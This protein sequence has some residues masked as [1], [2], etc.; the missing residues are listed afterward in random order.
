MDL[1]RESTTS[2][3]VAM[4]SRGRKVRRASNWLNA[5]I[6]GIQFPVSMA[7]GYFWGRER[8]KWF[9][10]APWLTAIFSLC[11]I[12]AGFVNLF[13]ITARAAREEER[14]RQEDEAGGGD[15][16]GDSRN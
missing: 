10:T 7:I 13:R 15:D 2:Y 16:G 1:D 4:S 3:S 12:D 9:G 8:D 5:S 14:M 11:G 6:V